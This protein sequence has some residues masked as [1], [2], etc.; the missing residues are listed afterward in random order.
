MPTGEVHIR[1]LLGEQVDNCPAIPESLCTECCDVL[2]L[3]ELTRCRRQHQF[4]ARQHTAGACGHR[5]EAPEPVDLL[6]GEDLTVSRSSEYHFRAL[7]ERQPHPVDAAKFTVL[8]DVIAR[9]AG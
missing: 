5:E 7:G 9:I 4:S 2:L 6:V 1:A 8:M 3:D